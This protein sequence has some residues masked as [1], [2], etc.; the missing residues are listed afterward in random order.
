MGKIFIESEFETIQLR[1][2][3]VQYIYIFFFFFLFFFF[4]FFLGGGT[5]ELIFLNY[6]KVVWPPISAKY[7]VSAW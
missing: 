7:N 1:I 6:Y 5:L 4:F 3:I 2:N